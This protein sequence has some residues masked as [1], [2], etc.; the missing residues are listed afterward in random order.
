M[1]GLFNGEQSTFLETISQK[2][3]NL[4]L[5][6]KGD[7]TEIMVQKIK[8]D[9]TFFIEPGDIN[10]LMEFFYIIDGEISYKSGEDNSIFI[11]GDYIYV[12]HLEESI[13]FKALTDVTMLYVSTQPVFHYLSKTVNDLV[14]LAEKVEEK[15]KYTYGHVERV[16]QYS[17]KIA[18]KLKLS[19]ERIETLSFASLFHDL[20]K[21]NVPDEI[22]NKPGRLDKDEF[23]Y[24][25]KHS[26]DGSEI[27][28]DTYYNNIGKI[29]VQHHE[30]LDGSGYPNGLMDKEILLEAKIIGVADTYDAMTSDRPYRKGLPPE[31]AVAELNRL[32][33]IHYDEKVVNAFIEVLIEEGIIKEEEIG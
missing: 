27:V 20:G 25:K 11:N 28:K 14:K 8:K 18:N 4:S 15:D 22:L 12:H 31:V 21:I 7:G 10:D 19:A 24:I 29:I 6:A 30:R 23:E 2:S 13:W 9:E 32:I 3:A 16:N 33:G 1:K 17:L 26:F 5:I